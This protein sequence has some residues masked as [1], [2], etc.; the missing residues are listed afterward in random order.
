MVIS[1]FVYFKLIVK[2]AL[3]KYIPLCD[4]LISERAK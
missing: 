2:V 1:F 3:Q 4:C